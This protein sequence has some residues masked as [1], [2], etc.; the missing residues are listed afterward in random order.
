MMLKI[1]CAVIAGVLILSALMGCATPL[2]PDKPPNG[3]DYK[4]ACGQ[5]DCGKDTK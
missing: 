4:A 3:F 5:D 1:I 2:V